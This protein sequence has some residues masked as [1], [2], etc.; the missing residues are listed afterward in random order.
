LT[1][2]CETVATDRGNIPAVAVGWNCFVLSPSA[3]L[4]DWAAGGIQLERLDPG[5]TQ[6]SASG[7]SGKHVGGLAPVLAAA[8][9]ADA[10]GGWLDAVAAVIRADSDGERRSGL[11]VRQAHGVWFHATFVKNRASILAHGLDW[12]RFVGS[13]IAGAQAPETDGIFL[14]SDIESA[15]L[16]VQM[17]RRRGREVDVWAVALDGQWL[18]S[19]P[20]SSGGLDDDWMIC[21]DPI[22]AQALE[23]RVPGQPG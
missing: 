7:P 2:V 13:G 21:P 8:A 19:D 22:P 10:D 4:E 14:C 18:V 1:F 17:G 15:A 6:W 9:G 20:S 3:D 5:G 23:L 16:F 11:M 12:S